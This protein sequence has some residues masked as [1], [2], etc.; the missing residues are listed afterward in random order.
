MIAMGQAWE[1]IIGYVEAGVARPVYD[2]ADVRR[3]M[4][5]PIRADPEH[6]DRFLDAHYMAG[7]AAE[8]ITTAIV[9]AMSMR[10]RS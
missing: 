5:A 8:R 7:D 4:Q 3:F 6:R 1:D 10:D 9:D 2:V